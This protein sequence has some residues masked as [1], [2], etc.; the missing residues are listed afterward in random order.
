MV[1]T[2]DSKMANSTSCLHFLSIK[3]GRRNKEIEQDTKGDITY[4]F[5]SPFYSWRWLGKKKKMTRN[6]GL[7]VPWNFLCIMPTLS[8][9]RDVSET[10][11]SS[12][13]KWLQHDLPH[14][15]TERSPEVRT[16]NVKDEL[17]IYKLASH[18]ALL[19]QSTKETTRGKNQP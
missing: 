1:L 6:W 16:E 11:F 15:F 8:K 10:Q 14:R 5:R 19:T 4:L 9:G 18:Q 7:N 12:S 13:V 3:K 2:T 17:K